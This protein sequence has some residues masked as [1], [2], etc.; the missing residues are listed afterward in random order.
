MTEGLKSA[1]SCVTWL[2]GLRAFGSQPKVDKVHS[3][4][5]GSIAFP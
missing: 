1:E 3:R 4:L 5:P 2:L